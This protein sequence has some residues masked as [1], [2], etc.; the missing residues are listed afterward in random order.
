ME[1]IQR[2][3]LKVS[4]LVALAQQGAEVV[5][6]IVAQRSTGNPRG[7][8]SVDNRSNDWAKRARSEAAPSAGGNCRLADNDARQRITQNHHL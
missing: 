8:P 6:F 2:M 4:P 7:E 5:N 3:A 1:F